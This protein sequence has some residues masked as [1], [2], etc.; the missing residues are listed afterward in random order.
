[1]EA[2]ARPVRYPALAT[3]AGFAVLVFMHL[4]PVRVFGGLIVFGTV[5]LRLFSFSLLPAVLALLHDATIGHAI[6][7]NSRGGRMA[8]LL[9]QLGVWAAE[10]PRATV[11]AGLVLIAIA[12]LGVSQITV[13]NNM[14]AWFKPGSEIR[15]ADAQINRALGGTPLGDVVAT[16]SE[17][18]AIK[19]P[20]SLRYIE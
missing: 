20:E 12:L 2:V 7:G 19:Q 3:A 5:A 15:I 1:M 4:V 17:P 18:D 9:R 11:A 10:R 14:V 8:G 13:N 16:A 6:G